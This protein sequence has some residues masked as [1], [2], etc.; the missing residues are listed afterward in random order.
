[1]Y[2]LFH[3]T[4]LYMYSPYMGITPPPLSGDVP[5]EDKKSK[6]IFY[7]TVSNVPGSFKQPKVPL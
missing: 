7:C 3:S 4:Y 5:T 2:T 1:M 6:T